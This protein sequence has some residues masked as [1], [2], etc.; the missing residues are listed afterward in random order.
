MLLADL[1]ATADAVAATSKRTEKV[2]HMVELFERAEPGELSLAVG[3]LA[4]EP[5]QGRLGVGWATVS[6]VDVTPASSPS[7]TVLDLDRTLTRLAEASGPGSAGVRTAELTDLFGRATPEEAAFV[8][9]LLGGEL[10][11]GALAAL[12][13]DALAKATGVPQ[14]V[15]RRA[16]MLS[17]DLAVVAD[18]VQAGGRSALEDIG[19]TLFRPVQPMLAATAASVADAI[20]ATAESSVEW[21]LDGIRVQVH[22]RGDEVAIYTRN[23][24]DITARLPGVVEL[25]RSFPADTFVLDGEAIGLGAD[26]RPDLFQDT[27]SRAGRLDDESGSVLVPRFFDC[28][29]LE[30]ADLIDRPLGERRTALESVVGALAVPATTTGDPEVAARVLDE[31]LATGH[32]G[33]VVKAIG[34]TYEAG[35]RGKN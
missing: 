31:S 28:L 22:R 16:V 2:A 19:L 27:M 18:A 24:N 15:V 14:T 26:E 20:E 29:H 32:E 8:R 10:R 4:S 5:R 12:V 9:R 35:R 17:G 33:V 6:A 21:K 34:S 30:G 25:V 1:V 13:A 11:H 3:L 7:V 23:L